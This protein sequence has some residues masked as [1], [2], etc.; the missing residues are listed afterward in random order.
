MK[1]WF[2]WAMLLGGLCG[3]GS[4]AV[5]HEIHAVNFLKLLKNWDSVSIVSLRDPSVRDPRVSGKTIRISNSIENADYR[6][7]DFMDRV[8]F[9]ADLVINRFMI[10]SA[11]SH[12]LIVELNES[13]NQQ[14]TRYKFI[15]TIERRLNK[16]YSFLRD[17]DRGVWTQLSQFPVSSVDLKFI[18]DLRSVPVSIKGSQKTWGFRDNDILMVTS[19]D[20]ESYRVSIPMP[21]SDSNHTRLLQLLRIPLTIKH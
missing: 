1:K 7:T 14:P 8:N 10:D 16:C 11:V 13:G 5:K 3:C 21:I 9:R 20:N 17:N 12:F 2:L 6:L 4:P 18:Q 19:I 15:I